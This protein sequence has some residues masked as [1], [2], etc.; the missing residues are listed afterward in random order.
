MGKKNGVSYPISG[1]GGVD[2]ALATKLK[3]LRIRTTARLLDAGR[4]AKGRQTLAKE[5]GI[6]AKQILQL[7]NKADL[8]RVKGIGDEYTSL[9]RAAGVDTLRELRLRSP[10]QL[11]RKMAAA[12]AKHNLVQLLPGE[13]AVERWIGQAKAIPLQIT[14]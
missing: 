6:P 9:L 2:P 1:I 11:A 12:N 8:M 3:T 4:H 10:A 5:T 7:V 14:Y 13:K